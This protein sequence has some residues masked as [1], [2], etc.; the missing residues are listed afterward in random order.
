[1]FP[2]DTMNYYDLYRIQQA[3]LHK[4]ANVQRFLAVKKTTSVRVRLGEALIVLG[5][6]LK[7]QPVQDVQLA[8]SAR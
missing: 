6:K 1:M 7:G 5:L 8:F 2:S 4:I 3:E